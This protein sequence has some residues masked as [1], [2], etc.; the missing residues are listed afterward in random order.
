KVTKRPAPPLPDAL[1]RVYPGCPAIRVPA[2]APKTTQLSGPNE[3]VPT[4]VL[5]RAAGERPTHH[6]P[7]P[8]ERHVAAPPKRRPAG[9]V[10]RAQAHR[11]DGARRASRGQRP[12]DLA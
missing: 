5:A 3:R 12:R 6:A 10:Q 8:A 9:R 2:T 4:R 11:G 7:A 1:L